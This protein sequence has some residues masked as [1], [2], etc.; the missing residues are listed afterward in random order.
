VP[1]LQQKVKNGRVGSERVQ[2]GHI[3]D[4]I[5][6]AAA[7]LFT[8]RAFSTRSHE[9]GNN[10]QPMNFDPSAFISISRAA[11]KSEQ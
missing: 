1:L 11:E 2:T 6:R 9:M 3:A 8:K 10:Q 7:G 4:R 5:D